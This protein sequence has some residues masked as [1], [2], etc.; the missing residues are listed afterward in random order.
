MI[1][2]SFSTTTNLTFYA[3]LS[4]LQNGMWL[5][6]DIEKY[7]KTFNISHGQFSILLVIYESHTESLTNDQIAIKLNRSK[8]TITKLI[9]KLIEEGHITYIKEKKDKRRKLYLLTTK[10]IDLL[11]QINPGYSER[12][13]DF[14]RNISEIEKYHLILILNKLNGKNYQV[15]QSVLTYKDKCDLIKPMCSSGSKLEID[16]VFSFFDDDVDIA[17]T[18]IID[19]YLSTVINLEGINRIE[20]YLFNG[21]QIQRNYSTLFFARRNEWE[22]VD[23][24]LKLGLIDNK[25]A[26][27]K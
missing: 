10:A 9:D 4:I 18:K 3:L 8:P 13:N 16:F 23:K 2:D 20:Y 26:Y 25:Q 1:Q 27:S 11:K 6:T 15:K 24:A 14:C 21:T 22:I 19:F 17:T 7:L 5:Q 12:I